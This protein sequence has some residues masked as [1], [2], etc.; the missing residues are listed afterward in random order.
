MCVDEISGQSQ[1]SK[2]G[3]ESWWHCLP[4]LCCPCELKEQVPVTPGAH[5]A[6]SSESGCASALSAPA[7]TGCSHWMWSEN[8]LKLCAGRRAQRPLSSAP[9]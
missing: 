3:A 9:S 5:L 1:A 7:F 2:E 4:Q 6:Q 8:T